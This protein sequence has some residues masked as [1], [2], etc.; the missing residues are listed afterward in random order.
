MMQFDDTAAHDGA[1]AG[2]LVVELGRRTGA[3]VCAS[4]L[5]QLGAQVV[6]VEPAQAQAD[7]DSLSDKWNWRDR[8]LAGKLSLAA[9]DAAT[10]KRLC[11]KADVV[12]TSSDVDAAFEWKGGHSQ[13]RCDVTAWGAGIDR[14]PCCESQMQALTGILATTGPSEGAPLPVPVPLVETLCGVHAA[15]AVLAA[16]R[17]AQRTGEGQAIDMALYDCGFAAMS[18]FFSRLLVADGGSDKVRRLGNQHTLSAPWNVYRASDGWM[19]ICTGSNCQWQRLCEVMGRAELA[20]A[21]RFLNSE[22]RVARVGEVDAIVQQWLGSQCVADCVEAFAQASIPG[23]PVA[24]VDGYPREPNLAHRAM[25]HRLEAGGMFVPGSPLRM[26]RTPGKVLMDVPQRGEGADAVRAL[27]DRAQTK[28][29]ARGDKQRTALEGLRVLEI[30]HYTTAPIAARHLGA[31]GADVVKIEP[32]QGE[33]ARAWAP[34]YQGQ[35]I[36]YTVSNSDKRDVTLDLAESEGRDLLREMLLGADVLLENLKPGTLAKHGFGRE[37]LAAL[38]PRLITCAISGFGADSIYAARPAFD[39]VVQGMS[40]LMDLIRCDGVPYKTGISTADVMG[41]AMA[42]V[43][44]L[45]ALHERERSGRGQFIDL[46]MQDIVA[47]ATQTVWNGGGPK[48]RLRQ[49]A[50]S[51]GALLAVGPCAAL[52]TKDMTRARATAVLQGRGVRF[53]PAMSPAEVVAAP[54]TLARRLYFRVSDGRG[55]WPALAVPLR[56]TGTPPAVRS[57]GPLLGADNH[58]M[59]VPLRAAA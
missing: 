35:S 47:W 24:P 44:V 2:V 19:M 50:C 49:L 17:H 6:V 52:D 23:G 26:S 39:T 48:P 36:F 9:E 18:S 27:L 38:N 40:G 13:V 56:L 15:G 10:L 4:L 33:A 11:G 8:M 58:D 54:E 31:L 12:I 25:V 37:A 46:S 57:P 43:A 34:M 21:P 16:L 45:G 1:L 32:P 5:A 51:D 59:A 20:Q 3:S 28:P 53:A 42:V 7:P 30:G 14:E 22:D 41:A 55:E 29:P